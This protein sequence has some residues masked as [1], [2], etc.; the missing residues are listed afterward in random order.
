MID[1]ILDEAWASGEIT[2]ETL[3]ADK[4]AQTQAGGFRHR[5]EGLSV[6][7]ADDLAA[8][9]PVPNKRVGPDARAVSPRRARLVRQRRKMA[10]ISH[11]AFTRALVADDLDIYLN[12]MH[13]EIRRYKR[14]EASPWRRLASRV[15]VIA[16]QV[17]A[18]F[19]L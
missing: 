2:L 14:C 17:L 16:T 4:A 11:V 13:R 10:E 8:G 5:R 18:R 7:L 3:S 12:A 6:R 19:R 1:T 15:K 9:L